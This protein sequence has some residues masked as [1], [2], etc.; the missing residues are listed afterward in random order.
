MTSVLQPEV[1]QWYRDCGRA[2]FEVVHVDHDAETI[3]IQYFDGTVEE[4]YLDEWE[5]DCEAGDI[6]RAAAPDGL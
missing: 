4:M 2:L 6:E 5:E 3:E 1:G